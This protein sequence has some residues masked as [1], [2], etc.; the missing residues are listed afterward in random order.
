MQSL[1]ASG[2]GRRCTRWFPPIVRM[3]HSHHR[4]FRRCSLAAQRLR[5]HPQGEGH[6]GPSHRSLLPA[7]PQQVIHLAAR[8]P[9]ERGLQTTLRSVGVLLL[10]PASGPLLAYVNP[11][12]SAA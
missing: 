9:R 2:T 4:N 6:S 11:H 12:H 5:K 1:R 7:A 3:A 8:N 10:W